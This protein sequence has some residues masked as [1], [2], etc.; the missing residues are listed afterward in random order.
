MRTQEKR[1]AIVVDRHESA[2]GT[3]AHN[4]ARADSRVLVLAAM[5]YR[6]PRALLCRLAEQSLD[7][8]IY[9]WRFAAWEMMILKKSSQRLNS[10]PGSPL[11]AVLI[12]DYLGTFDPTRRKELE[13]LEAIDYFLVTNCS[14][15]EIYSNTFP[16]KFRGILHDLPDDNLIQNLNPSDLE[17]QDRKGIIWIGNSKWGQNFGLIDH[18]GYREI[19]QPI[20]SV[21]AT[22]PFTC[23]DSAHGIT[24]HPVVLA[25]LKQSRYLIHASKNE[26]TGLPILEAMGMGTIPITTNVGIAAE[27]IPEEL[28]FLIVERNP[29]DFLRCYAKLEEM[30]LASLS[31]RVR[32]AYAQFLE[33]ARREPMLFQTEKASRTITASPHSRV[34]VRVKWLLRHLKYGSDTS[35]D[36]ELG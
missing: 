21:L 24:P 25:Q 32:S 27:V 23:I 28:K 12:P 26:G 29:K 22:V 8:I 35:L 30:S 7:L 11:V 6:S 3:S 5:D 17:I 13:L 20:A 2:L 4:R 19:V 34:A 10:L 36:H 18:K 14:L 9:S 1:I 15:A 16:T 33:K 31:Q